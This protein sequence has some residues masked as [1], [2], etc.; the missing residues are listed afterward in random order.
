MI[1]ERKKLD[2]K[3][4]LGYILGWLVALIVVFGAVGGLVFARQHTVQ[5]Q[6]VQLRLAQK[7]GPHV[8][9]KRAL[10]AP[11]HR[12]IEVPGKLHGFIETALYAKT[13]G[14]LK[15]IKVDKGDRVTQGEVLAIL[16]SPE[17][18]K[19]VADAKANYWLQKTTDDRAAK[20]AQLGVMP[21]QQ[22]DDAHAAMMQAQAAYQQLLAEQAYEIIRAPFS[23]IVT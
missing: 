13:A 6:A 2:R 10:P 12:T 1:D 20:L 15:I 11:A 9:V 3:P 19:Q 14:Y 17:L 16:D 8:L 23:G 7:S 22:A 5:L 21:Q 4:G 18:D